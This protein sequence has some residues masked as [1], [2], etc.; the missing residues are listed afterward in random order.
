MVGGRARFEVLTVILLCLRE[1]A[2]AFA[3]P[4]RSV[5]RTD[6]MNTCSSGKSCIW[7]LA[8]SRNV[9]AVKCFDGVNHA[10]P[11][12]PGLNSTVTKRV[13]GV[14]FPR[15]TSLTFTYTEIG[16]SFARNKHQIFGS[17]HAISEP[18]RGISCFNLDP[19]LQ[20]P[21]IDNTRSALQCAIP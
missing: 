5:P 13:I 3:K 19:A 16:F 18:C 21:S 2:L 7:M 4:M 11:K 20:K 1:L 17:R 15:Y 10:T 6:T 12:R 9:V 8:G 14:S